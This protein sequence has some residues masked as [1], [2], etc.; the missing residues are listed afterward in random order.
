MNIYQ[1]SFVYDGVEYREHLLGV[2]SDYIKAREFELGF[3]A[4][5]R[6]TDSQETRIMKIELD[7][8]Y[9][10]KVGERC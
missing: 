4:K 9:E 1:V 8:Q 7:K 3:L 10:F 2:F 5:R 6:L